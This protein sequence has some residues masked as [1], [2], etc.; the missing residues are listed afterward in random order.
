MLIFWWWLDVW[1]HWFAMLE[2]A[3]PP[4]R[5]D[6]PPDHPGKII[7]LEDWRRS[8]PHGRAA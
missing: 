2:M 1:S 6:P 5:P 4:P 7:D 8:H 3:V